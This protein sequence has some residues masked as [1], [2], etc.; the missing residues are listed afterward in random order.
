MGPGSSALSNVSWSWFIVA[1]SPRLALIDSNLGSLPLYCCWESA[2]CLLSI[3]FCHSLF[4]CSTLHYSTSCICVASPYAT[5]L[6]FQLLFSLSSFYSLSTVW[7][8]KLEFKVPDSQ[9]CLNKSSFLLQN[10]SHL[11]VL[12]FSQ[13]NQKNHSTTVNTNNLQITVECPHC[14]W[15]S[16]N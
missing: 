1:H 3:F 11:F 14:C 6:G 15:D 7:L 13:N 12:M 9:F 2:K 10:V 4:L 5:D 8:V 16:A